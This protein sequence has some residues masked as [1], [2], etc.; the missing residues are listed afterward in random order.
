MDRSTGYWW[1][2]DESAHRVHA[3]RRVAGRRG[4]ALR[5]PRRLGARDP[6]ALSG[7]RAAERRRAAVDRALQRDPDGALHVAPPVRARRRR[8]AGRLPRAR[9]LVPGR[10]RTRRAVAE[11]RPADAGPAPRRR[12]DRPRAGPARGAQ[13]QLGAAAR[14]AHLPA[15]A[16][17]LPLGLEPQRLPAPVP[18]RLRRA[19]RRPRDR[20][21]VDGRPA[22]AASARSRRST[23]SA[24]L[25]YFTANRETPIE[26][27]LYSA[28]LDGPSAAAAIERRPATPDDA[29][30]LALGGDVAAMR[31]SGSTPSRTPTRRPRWRCGASAA[32][33]STS[34][35]P[36]RLDATHPYAP[37]L[38]A[39]AADRIRHAARRR[40][41]D[42][43]T[44]R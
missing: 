11:P 42:C 26:R 37:F 27:H 17:R 19:L 6:P 39:H 38:A 10:Q 5:D 9:R 40:R 2:P 7:G 18:V 23:S 24:G 44:T 32:P 34:S 3:R 4:R 1:S 15:A 8:D 30:R 29:R 20:G 16:P 41:P 22:M 35:C 28:P 21:R 12:G 36:N 33:R 31:G 25:V 43:C 14:R 13:R